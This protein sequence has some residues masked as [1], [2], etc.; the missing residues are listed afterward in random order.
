MRVLVTGGCGFPGGWVVRAGLPQT[1]VAD[2]I[3][4]TLAHCR[5]FDITLK[6][7]GERGCSSSSATRSPR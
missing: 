5:E 7:D 1:D 4:R 6:L 3:A 2:G